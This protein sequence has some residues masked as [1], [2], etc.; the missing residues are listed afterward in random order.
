M[1]CFTGDPIP[2]VVP[3]P[4]QPS[5]NSGHEGNGNFMCTRHLTGHVCEKLKY[6]VTDF[7][8]LIQN[9]SSNQ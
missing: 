8:W 5:W 2:T 3:T 4:E 1:Y 6:A 9:T 7:L